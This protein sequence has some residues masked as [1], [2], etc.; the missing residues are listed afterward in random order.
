MSLLLEGGG[1]AKFSVLPKMSER[2]GALCLRAT[3]G[4][5]LAIASYTFSAC[6]SKCLLLRNR[7]QSVGCFV[8]LVEL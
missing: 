2:E 1:T 3:I 7:L 8:C 6:E 4:L 5:S